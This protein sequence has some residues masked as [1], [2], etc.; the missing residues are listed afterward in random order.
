[1]PLMIEIELDEARSEQFESVKRDL[2]EERDGDLTEADI[3]DVL[4][5]AYRNS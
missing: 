3:I 1:M 5:E 2:R 4:I